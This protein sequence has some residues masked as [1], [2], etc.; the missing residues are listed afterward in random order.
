M[1]KLTYLAAVFLSIAL[2]PPG[3]AYIRNTGIGL[4]YTSS[5][6]IIPKGTFAITNFSRFFFKDQLISVAPAVQ[7]GVTIWD[8]QN[9]LAFSYGLAEKFEITL[10]QLIYQDTNTSGKGYVLPGDF[11][12]FGKLGAFHLPNSGIRLA[13]QA[14][15]RFP[16][17][18]DHNILFEPYC[19]GRTEFG[20]KG[21]FS[22]YSEPN[23]VTAGSNI[24]LNLDFISHNDL[25]KP[26]SA[27]PADP[28]STNTTRE[29]LYSLAFAKSA[30]EFEWA[31][32]LHGNVFLTQP[33]FNA[34]S[35]E[36]AVFF[37]PSVKFSPN[38]WFGL[39]VGVDVRMSADRD[40]TVY[41]YG[42]AKPSQGLPNYPPWRLHGSLRLQGGRKIASPAQKKIDSIGSNITIIDEIQSRDQMIYEK[43][44]QER[45]KT[46]SA[47]EELERIRK[48]RERMEK[49]LEQLRNVLNWNKKPDQKSK[50]ETSQ[51]DA[52]P[53]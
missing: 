22:W 36:S 40:Q 17:A 50:T 6:L 39:Q 14:L 26:L 16:V 45:K 4:A 13:L 38:R 51:P 42:T 28:G 35:R 44:V 34:Y 48:E 32:E 24:H 41:L 31:L 25:Q 11:F 33:V 29:L 10:A 5:A 20:F 52:P 43:L 49:M 46:E 37:T 15:M 9:G 3:S 53:K 23:F 27:H 12:L 30:G 47:E 21:I 18:A 1:K 19:A 7:I 8:I 2:A